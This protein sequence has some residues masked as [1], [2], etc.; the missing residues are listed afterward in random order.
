MLDGI[1]SNKSMHAQ[2]MKGY[3]IG[4]PQWDET[5]AA[6]M[7]S[8]DLVTSQVK[9]YMDVNTVFHCLDLGR[10][11]LWSTAFAPNHTREVNKFLETI[12][13]RSLNVSGRC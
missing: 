8:P 6:I 2:L 7:A 11:H 4:V 5:A 3:Y 1:T 10:T 13:R 9:A 12:R